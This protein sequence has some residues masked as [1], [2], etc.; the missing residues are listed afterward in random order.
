MLAAERTYL[1]PE[2]RVST[3]GGRSFTP[4]IES[5]VIRIIPRE[6]KDYDQRKCCECVHQLFKKM[7]IF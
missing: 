4:S 2:I 5:G 6:P 1:L 7:Y 3:P